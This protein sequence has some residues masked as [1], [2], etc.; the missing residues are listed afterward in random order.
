VERA[1]VR[2]VPRL[3]LILAALGVAAVLVLAGVLVA[4][5]SDDGPFQGEPDLPSGY[6]TYEGDVGGQR[7]SFAYPRDWGEP[8]RDEGRLSVT[9]ETQG[10]RSAEGTRP[11]LQ[12]RIRPETGADFTAAFEIAKQQTRLSAGLDTRISD[13]RDVEL[14]GADEARVVE[15]RFDVPTDSG[16]EPARGLGLFAMTPGET[17]VVYLVVATESTEFDPLPTFESFRLED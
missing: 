12:A 2:S 16:R 17:F 14:D 1:A 9:F 8:E 11:L 5:S 10:E 3:V 6:V 4:G 7:F 13:E 15:Y